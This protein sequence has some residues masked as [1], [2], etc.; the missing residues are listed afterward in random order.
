MDENIVLS[1]KLRRV[2]AGLTQRDVASR[3]GITATRL[4][5]IER[6]VVSP[7]ERDAEHL[8]SVLP[9]FPA[10]C[11]QLLWGQIGFS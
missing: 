11:A 4:S 2:A 10:R 7:T 3:A 8:E 1:W 9:M 6:G 5:A